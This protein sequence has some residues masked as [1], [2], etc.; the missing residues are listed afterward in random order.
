[1]KEPLSK[2]DPTDLTLNDKLVSINRVA[3]VMRGGKRLSFSALVV[4][5]DG[6]G[7]VGIG[8]GKANEVPAYLP[9][10]PPK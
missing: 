2:I 10:F 1:M 9:L 4:T 5:G 8:V 3:K 6:E 7:H